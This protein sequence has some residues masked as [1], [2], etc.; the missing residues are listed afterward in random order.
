MVNSRLSIDLAGIKL[1]SPLVLASG[2][3]GLSASSL[4]R[5]AKLGAGAVTSKS[6]GLEERKGHPCPAILPFQHGLLNAVGLANPGIEEM[7]AELEEFRKIS[8]VPV[9]ASIFGKTVEEF[10]PAARVI[11]RIRPAMIEVNVSCPNVAA[12]FGQSFATDPELVGQITRLVRNEV[13]DIP[14]SIKISTQCLSIAQVAK[15]A[16]QNG[17]DAITAINSIGPGMIIDPEVRRPVLANL[18]GGMS[19][20]AILPIAVK[21]VWDVRKAVSIPII[22]T[23]GVETA[24]DVLQMVL[25][26]AT[27]V[28]IGTAVYTRG[29]DVFSAINHDLTDYLEKHSIASISELT[30]AAHV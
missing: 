13:K 7:A 11:A 28:G 18:I 25:A 10:A 30:G 3:M 26:G 6:S 21:A 9:I 22:G 23:G 15:A 12:E 4:D 5:V 14:I 17:A 24:E 27:A 29:L 20:P 19:G 8:D 2:I 16:E 1:A